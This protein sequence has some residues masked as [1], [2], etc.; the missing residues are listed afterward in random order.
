MFQE[1][2]ISSKEKSVVAVV[3]GVDVERRAT[4]PGNRLD[5][6]TLN[7]VGNGF[8]TGPLPPFPFFDFFFRGALALAVLS[9][10]EEVDSD[11][12]GMEY[13]RLEPCLMEVGLRGEADL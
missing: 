10:R 4:N 5:C 3:V 7:I 11:F 12:V 2:K 6:P 9:E 1:E 13:F 8:G